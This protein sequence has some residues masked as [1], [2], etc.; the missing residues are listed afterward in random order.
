[1]KILQFKNAAGLAA[2]ATVTLLTGYTYAATFTLN[3]EARLKDVEAA[4]K[5]PL[6]L[7][8]D[9]GSVTAPGV[10][11]RPSVARPGKPGIAPGFTVV[12][13]EHAETGAE[14]AGRLLAP[15][16]S[17][18]DVP[19]PHPDLATKSEVD[20]P[21][22]GPTVYGRREPGGGVLGLRVPIPVDRSR[23]GGSTRYGTPSDRPSGASTIR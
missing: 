7:V 17:D 15:Q 2:A 14:I 6:S 22:A 23:S 9:T 5:G 18:P 16:A 1:M 3:L 13:P 19:L 11:A 21:L 8:A 20:R 10:P 4:D 12:A